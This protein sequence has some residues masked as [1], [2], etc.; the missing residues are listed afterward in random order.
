MPGMDERPRKSPEQ[1]GRGWWVA[2]LALPFF[3]LVLYPLSIGP[4]SWMLEHGWLDMKVAIIFYEPLDWLY[5]RAPEP[6]QRAV[7]SYQRLWAEQ[8]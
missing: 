6:L 4:A 3:V 5:D 1:K 2:V 8:P 7:D